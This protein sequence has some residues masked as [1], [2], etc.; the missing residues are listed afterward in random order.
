MKTL[1]IAIPVT[2]YR[3]DNY[4]AALAALGAEPVQVT[5]PV[6][7]DSFDGLL[8]PGGADINPSLYGEENNG[9]KGIDDSLDELQFGALDAFVKA[10]KPVL[11]ICRGHQVINVYFG[12]TMIQDLPSAGRHA[13]DAG[14][15]E[16]KIH[17]NHTEPGTLLAKLYGEEFTSNSSHHQAAGKIGEG[18][19]VMAR[20]DDGVIEA[21][22]HETLPILGI[23]FHPERMCLSFANDRTADGL[24]IFQEFLHTVRQGDG[25]PV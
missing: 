22:C 10:G 18:L 14:Q 12:G 17:L 3:P 20:S 19:R 16:D 9:S 21:L 15:A 25:S 8:L 11:G 24:R 4:M 5:E 23:Q 1:K 6:S 7:A 2:D 13:R